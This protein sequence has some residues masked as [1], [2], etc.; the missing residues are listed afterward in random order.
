MRR[1]YIAIE[2]LYLLGLAAAALILMLVY[3]SRGFQ[4]N[5]RVQADQLGVQYSPKDMQTNITQVWKVQRS[6]YIEGDGDYY[7]ATTAETMT[8]KGN[9]NVVT[10][11]R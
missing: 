10:P 11:L 7:K 3:I 5:L 2:Y 4:G 1:A 8:N 9:E 6:D